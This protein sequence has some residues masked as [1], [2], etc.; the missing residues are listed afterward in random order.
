MM[1]VSLCYQMKSVSLVIFQPHVRAGD[2]PRPFPD[3][4]QDKWDA[5]HVRMPCSPENLYP[6][7]DKVCWDYCTEDI[8]TGQDKFR[9]CTLLLN[10]NTERNI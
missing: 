6:V 3:H 1:C 9:M 4:Y 8:V 7:E 10:M 5:Y 2:P